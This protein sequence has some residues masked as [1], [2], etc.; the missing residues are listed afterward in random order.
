MALG[1]REFVEEVEKYYD[2]IEQKRKTKKAEMS[3]PANQRLKLSLIDIEEYESDIFEITVALHRLFIMQPSINNLS[4]ADTEKIIKKAKLIAFAGIISIFKRFDNKN[5]NNF[6]QYYSN[7]ASL[8]V[9]DSFF[10][11][12]IKSALVDEGL[13]VKKLDKNDTYTDLIAREAILPDSIIIDILYIFNLYKKYFYPTLLIKDFFKELNQKDYHNMLPLIPDLEEREEANNIYKRLS[14]IKDKT[15][16]TLVELMRFNNYINIGI[17]PLSK[18]TLN[19][20]VSQFKEKFEADVSEIF[21]TEDLKSTFLNMFPSFYSFQFKR[22]LN[23]Y[24]DSVKIT[25]PDN[26]TKTVAEIKEQ[27]SLDFGV[28]KIEDKNFTVTPNQAK[29]LSLFL[30]IPKE[31][32]T[33]QA[34]KAMVLSD[35]EIET[36]LG[37][38]KTLNQPSKIYSE[39]V[40]QGY[41]WYG[42]KPLLEPLTVLNYEGEIDSYQPVE[43]LISNLNLKLKGKERNPY[44][45]LDLDYLLIVSKENKGKKVKIID[46]EQNNNSKEFII[47]SVGYSG[48]IPFKIKSKKPGL[49]TMY[50]TSNDEPLDLKQFESRLNFDIENYILFDSHTGN[51]VAPSSK[52]YFGCSN[53]LYLFTTKEFDGKWVNDVC[54]VSV[55]QNFGRFNVYEIDWVET[56]KPIELNINSYFKWKF[57]NLCTFESTVKHNNYPNTKY[58]SYGKNYFH[59]IKDIHINL[60]PNCNVIKAGNIDIKVSFNYDVVSPHMKLGAVNDLL[61][62][63]FNSTEIDE[64]VIKALLPNFKELSYGRYDFEF[65]YEDSILLKHSAFV[66]PEFEI[67]EDKDVYLEGDDIVLTLSSKTPCF[68]NGKTLQNY[69]FDDPAKC[70]FVIN[71]N[72]MIEFKKTHYHKTAKLYNPYVEIPLKYDPEIIG[73]RFMQDNRLYQADKLD[74]YDI[75]KNTLVIKASQRDSRLKINGSSVK[76]LIPNNSGIILEPIISSKSDISKNSNDVSIQ[77]GKNELDFEIVWNTKVSKL[78][79]E[80]VFYSAEQ[81]ISFLMSYEGANQSTLK[82]IMTDKDGKS[83]DIRKITSGDDNAAKFVRYD[84]QK[85]CVLITCDGRKWEDRQFTFHLD[86]KVIGDLENVFLE[87]IYEDNKE[88]FGKLVFKNEGAYP[89]L[90]EINDRLREEKD[91]PYTYFERGFLYSEMNMFI[92]AEQDFNHSLKLGLDDEEANNY[93]EVFKESQINNLLTYELSQITR[94]ARKL[95]TDELLLEVE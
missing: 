85:N 46:T 48:K 83:L 35:S 50:L 53:K 31:K 9:N 15:S 49:I 74:Y 11:K 14:E 17:K 61:G 95:Y 57:N 52:P 80:N 21:K 72:K 55:Y 36:F 75:E 7:E 19:D 13:I 44:F 67:T 3:L 30:A 41:L 78:A 23:E 76:N 56:S 20:Y 42:N 47:D 64:T 69:L 33:I 18:D 4:N 32:I 60:V 38:I 73:Y 81:G 24:D 89:E 94:L 77:I 59:N 58:I 65:S 37:P 29:D 34:N 82:F 87:G 10:D 43:N 91:N 22:F 16:E 70:N 92:L 88:T 5:W 66:V 1:S 79:C 93:I 6:W 12:I 27:E 63:D 8:S 90:K 26:S 25:L 86:P 28:Y 40:L 71:S 54:E 2:L 39:G 84:R 45:E 68:R 62:K 51:R